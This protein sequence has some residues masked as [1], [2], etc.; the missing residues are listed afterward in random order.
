M[1][2]FIFKGRT[3]NHTLTIVIPSLTPKSRGQIEA[4]IK[5]Q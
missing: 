4:L 2:S 3:I 1:L 5:N